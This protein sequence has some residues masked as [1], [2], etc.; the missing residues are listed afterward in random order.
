[1]V[2]PRPMMTRRQG[3]E[4]LNNEGFP[5]TLHAL[6]KACLPTCP[7]RLEPD[8]FWGRI[9][10][11]TPETL[12]AWARAKLRPVSVSASASTIAA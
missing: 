3:V 12:L 7:H 9:P 2:T 6:N 1:M 8:Q 4:F 5:V 10:L 11:Y